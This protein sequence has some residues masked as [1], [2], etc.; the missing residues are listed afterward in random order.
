MQPRLRTFLALPV[1]PTQRH[2]LQALRDELAV[3]VDGVKWVEPDN[4]HL[5]LL[6]LGE[7]ATRETVDICRAASTA[8]VTVAPF[9]LR[10]QGLGC[11]PHARRPRV[12]WVGVDS[13]KEHVIAVHDAL[14][15]SLLEL[16]CY[17]REERPYAPHVTLG[18]VSTPAE[19]NLAR[20]LE[21]Y[22]DWLGGAGPVH[23]VHI[24]ASELGRDGPRYTLLGRAKLLGPATQ[25]CDEQP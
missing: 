22:R 16:G 14:E 23:E 17:R 11:F 15:A 2:R 25:G 1:T 4:L 7:V 6:F 12:L 9:T 24:M 3:R 18:R 13:G 20:Q 19:P 10:L 21:T 8:M 5:T